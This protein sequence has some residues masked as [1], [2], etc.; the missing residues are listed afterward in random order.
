MISVSLVS[1][2]SIFSERSWGSP[3]SVG[4]LSL[5]FVL[6]E[7]KYMSHSGLPLLVPNARIGVSSAKT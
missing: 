7:H 4:V 1:G 2:A 6:K 5:A 3:S